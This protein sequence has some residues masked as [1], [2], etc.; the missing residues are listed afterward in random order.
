M[1]AKDREIDEL[2]RKLSHALYQRPST[3]PAWHTDAAHQQDGFGHTGHAANARPQRPMKS[4]TLA[5]LQ[6][7]LQQAQVGGCRECL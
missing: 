5:A 3:A 6:G 7:Q 2:T 1:R 4:P